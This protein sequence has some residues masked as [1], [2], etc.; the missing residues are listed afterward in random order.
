MNITAKKKPYR[1][2]E[3]ASGYLWGEKVGEV[4]D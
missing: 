4:E 1:Y 3:Q 2:R